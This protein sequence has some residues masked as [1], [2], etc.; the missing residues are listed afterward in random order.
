MSK[1]ISEIEY[2]NPKCNYWGVNYIIKGYKCSRCGEINSINNGMRSER[3]LVC[4]NCG[5]RME[6]H[7]E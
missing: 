5:A 1:W 3:L 6:A 2:I 7:N 4:P